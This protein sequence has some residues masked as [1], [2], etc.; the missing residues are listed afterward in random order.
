MWKMENILCNVSA[1]VLYPKAVY[2][3]LNKVEIDWFYKL[4]ENIENIIEKYD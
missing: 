1:T 2:H 3:A 4:T